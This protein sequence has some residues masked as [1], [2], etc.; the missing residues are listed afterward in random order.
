MSET[1]SQRTDG[2]SLPGGDFRLFVQK[3]AF[4]TLLGLGL[5]EN[6][7]TRRKEVNLPQAKSVLND[8]VMLREKTRGNLERDEDE[9]LSRVIRDL[10]HQ[11]VSLSRGAGGR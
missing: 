8:L 6:P 1:A 5:F 2:S 11:F 3:L 9:H 7:L 4:Q 10:E